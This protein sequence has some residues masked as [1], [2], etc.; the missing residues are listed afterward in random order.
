MLKQAYINEINFQIETEIN[1]NE[2]NSELVD[3][4]CNLS[5]ED[6]E[7]IA[8]KMIDDDYLNEIINNTI[9]DYLYEDYEQIIN[10]K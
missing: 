5:S 7:K 4:L 8:D 3:Y 1:E 2:D 6:I 9:I 10:N